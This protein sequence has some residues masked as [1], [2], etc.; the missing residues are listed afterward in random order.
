MSK[1]KM[2]KRLVSFSMTVILLFAELPLSAFAGQEDEKTDVQIS[3]EMAS[4]DQTTDSLEN[5]NTTLG[6]TDYQDDDNVI[7]IQEDLDGNH[8]SETDTSVKTDETATAE[9]TAGDTFTDDGFSYEVNDDNLTVCITDHDDNSVVTLNIPDSVTYDGYEYEVS[10]IDNSVFSNYKNLEKVTLPDTLKSLGYGVFNNCT[11]LDNVKIP[12]SITKVDSYTGIFKGCTSLKTITLEKGV[13]WIGPIFKDCASLESFEIPDTV[14]K[15]AERAFQDC[16]G[17]KS[18]TIGEG[19][20]EI[21]GNAFSGCSSLTSVEIPDSV[22]SIGDYAF[23]GC[24]KLETIELSKNLETLGYGVFCNCISLNDVEIPKSIKSVGTYFGIFKGCTNLKDVT[25]EKGSD[26]LGPIFKDCA[27]LE[28]FEIPDTVTKIAE[29]AFQDCSGLKSVTIGEGVEEIGGNAFSGCSSLT[30]VEIPDSVTSIG[31]YAFDGCSKLETIELSKNLETLG[32]GVFCNCTSLNNVEI[33]KSIKSVGT[34]FGVFKGCTNL[35]NV[36][37]E[38]GTDWIGPIFKDCASLETIE[39]PDTVTQI[40]ENAFRDCTGLKEISI[41]ES[42]EIINENAFQGCINL[43]SIQL[44]EGLTTIKDYAFGNCKSLKEL[45]I[46]ASVSK[47]G[48]YNNLFNSIPEIKLLVNRNSYA[49][50]YA[51]IYGMDFEWIGDVEPGEDASLVRSMCQ[52]VTQTNGVTNGYIEYCLDY[53]FKSKIRNSITNPKVTM[54]IPNDT[55]LVESSITVNGVICTDY[56]YDD[57]NRELVV[58][59]SNSNGEV[60]FRVKAERMDSFYSYA[61]IEF[62]RGNVHYME[63]IGCAQSEISELTL[64]MDDETETGVFSV[65]GL[66]LPENTVKLYVG[67]TKVKD[68]KASKAGVYN[69]SITIPDVKKYKTYTVK[70][71]S[72]N[73]DGDDIEA[74][75]FIT[76]I[77]TAPKLLHFTMEHNGQKYDLEELKGL[78]PIVTFSSGSDF[79]F[80]ASFSNA[81]DIKAVYFVSTRNNEKKKM[82]ASRDSKSGVFKASGYFDPENTGYVPGTITIEYVKDGYVNYLDED[83]DFSSD[84]YANSLPEEMDGATIK[85]ITDTEDVFKAKLSFP[86]MGNESVDLVVTTEDIPDDLTEEKALKQGFI[87]IDPEALEDLEPSDKTVLEEMGLSVEMI[88]GEDQER[89]FRIFMDPI[90]GEVKSQCIDFVHGKLD[91]IEGAY[92]MLDL[93]DN[94]STVSGWMNSAITYENN[95]VDINAAKN[96]I[97]SSKMS[98]GEKDAALR[99]VRAAEALNNEKIAMKVAGVI[100][101]AAGLSCPALGFT[102]GAI[103]FLSDMELK[104][105]MLDLDEFTSKTSGSADINFRWAIDPSGYIYDEETEERLSGATVTLYYKEKEGDAPVEWDA[106]EYLQLNPLVSADDGT[107]AWDVPEGLWQVKAE[108]EGYETGYSEWLIVPPPQTDVAINIKKSGQKGGK[109]KD[110]SENE[111]GEGST[112]PTPTELPVVQPTQSPTQVPTQMPA[113][114]TSLSPTS[115]PTSVPQTQA[116]EKSIRISS[117]TGTVSKLQ[118]KKGRKLVIKWKKVSGADGYDIWISKKKNFS[119]PIKY[120]G[121]GSSETIILTKKFRKKKVYVKIRPYI[122]NKNYEKVTGNWSDIK[123]TKIKK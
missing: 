101:A 74:K 45:Y 84:E 43:E 42:V 29:R 98:Q 91:T 82:K 109:D 46:P 26:W 107:Y 12:K 54:Y 66:A 100:V 21:G 13:T 50:M 94:Y 90:S 48:W 18:V 63:M 47:M 49:A 4:E 5:N 89:L 86:G 103:S 25:L 39:I 10:R 80:E 99:H 93:Y 44:C 38:K 14:T 104:R 108:L 95:R 61:F 28:S 105:T 58:P 83:I 72:Q 68:V 55:S 113:Q 117:S 120:D 118:S 32:Y 9:L 23:D 30:S 85:V 27:S 119:S 40:G 6:D 33:P 123:S 122:W 97:M 121:T 59:V 69:A 111:S 35:K 41:P 2:I 106:G 56:D 88:S 64:D 67:N 8:I 3:E 60:R 112:I 31:D 92:G 52:Y 73:A 16:S 78:K 24:S 71:V 70:A 114:V 7:L 62:N 37:L 65:G 79:K 19:V 110:K 36:T 11:R 75:G 22:T 87:K 20:E 1:R 81:D 34:Y 102:L 116:D 57:A 96:R 115:Q 76:C 15:I 17:L 77:P 51:I 53:G